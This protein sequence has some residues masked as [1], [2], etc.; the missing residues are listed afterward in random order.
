MPASMMSADAGGST[1]VIGKSSDIVA[2]EPKAGKTPMTWQAFGHLSEADL[3]S[4]FAYLRS[5]P[6]VPNRVPAYQPPR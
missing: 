5:L 6:A 1:Q 4:I 3:R 2:S